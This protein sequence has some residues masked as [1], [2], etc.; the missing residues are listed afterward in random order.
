M[1]FNPSPKVPGKLKCEVFG[2]NSINLKQFVCSTRASEILILLLRRLR[3]VFLSPFNL[4]ICT[5]NC[6]TETEG[7]Q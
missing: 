2:Y 3:G 5:V 6:T 1:N 7:I 4:D